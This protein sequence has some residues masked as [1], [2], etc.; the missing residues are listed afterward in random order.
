MHRLAASNPHEIKQQTSLLS[1]PA[2]ELL[3]AFGEGNATPGSGSAAALMGLLSC[4]LIR[5]VAIKTL[6]KED[7]REQWNLFRLINEQLE[8]EIE[9]KLK[10]L[11]ESDAAD[12]E[13]VVDLRK[14]ADQEPDPKL[15]ARYNRQSNDILEIATNYVF[16][17]SDLCLKLIDHGIAAFE[18]GWHAVRGDSGASVSVAISGVMSGIFIVNLNLKRLK[19]RQYSKNNLG[20][21]QQLTRDMQVKQT[22]AFECITSIGSETLDAIQLT[23]PEAPNN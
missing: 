17:T 19:R 9:P 13:K 1:R 3:H 8:S 6:E 15:K 7:C 18:N 10:E 12:F 23:L 5:T 16:E 20:R 14:L 4:R 2:N 22:R 21:C 11:F